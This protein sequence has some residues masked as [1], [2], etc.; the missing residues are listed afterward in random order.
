MLFFLCIPGYKTSHSGQALTMIT[1][2]SPKQKRHNCLKSVEKTE[3]SE[4]CR[5]ERTRMAN[6]EQEVH[7]Y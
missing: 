5:E 2:A 3:L 7:Y 6:M 1:A 4:E